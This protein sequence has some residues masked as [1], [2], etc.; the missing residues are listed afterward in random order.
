MLDHQVVVGG[1]VAVDHA[2]DDALCTAQPTV[3]VGDIGQGEE[4]FGGV[5][6]AVGAAIRP[7]LHSSRD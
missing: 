4:S 7:P 6:V 5:H 3:V 1:G 2:L